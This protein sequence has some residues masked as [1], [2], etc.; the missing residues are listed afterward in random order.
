MYRTK[1]A[2]SCAARNNPCL[3]HPSR[4]FLAKNRKKRD[5]KKNEEKI[6]TKRKRQQTEKNSSNPTEDVRKDLNAIRVAPPKFADHSNACQLPMLGHLSA[7]AAVEQET[8]QTLRHYCW[9]VFCVFAE[10]FSAGHKFFGDRKSSLL[11]R[12]SSIWDQFWLSAVYSF[13]TAW[14]FIFAKRVIFGKSP[15]ARSRLLT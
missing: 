4:R 9:D 5:P 11:L 13:S 10:R 14:C 1:I 2:E 7:I 12:S 15:T 3:P 6:Y 8:L